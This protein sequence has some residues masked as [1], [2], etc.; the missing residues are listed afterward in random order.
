MELAKALRDF[1]ESTAEAADRLEVPRRTLD[2]KIARYGCV[3]CRVERNSASG[4]AHQAE[5]RQLRL[6][7]PVQTRG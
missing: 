7:K 1:G 5:I 2:E 6:L 3:N 4:A